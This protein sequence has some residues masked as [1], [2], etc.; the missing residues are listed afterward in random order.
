MSKLD[1]NDHVDPL[2]SDQTLSYLLRA[3]A[4]LTSETPHGLT[5][6]YS[7]KDLGTKSQRGFADLDALLAYLEKLEIAVDEP[8]DRNEAD[9]ER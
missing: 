2:N 6:R 7:L 5:W 3:W 4:E 8:R 9:Q 1:T